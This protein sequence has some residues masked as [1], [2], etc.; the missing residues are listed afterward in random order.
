MSKYFI[1]CSIF[2]FVIA[3]DLVVLLIKYENDGVLCVAELGDHYHL[4]LK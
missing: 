1:E 4:L 3:T 2:L